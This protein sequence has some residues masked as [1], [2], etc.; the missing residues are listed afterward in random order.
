MESEL[1]DLTQRF[2]ILGQ[3]RDEEWTI[4]E[5][6]R[7]E[8]SNKADDLALRLLKARSFIHSTLSLEYGPTNEPSKP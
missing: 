4:M 3:T 6:R 8:A 1:A 2:T 7:A 5:A